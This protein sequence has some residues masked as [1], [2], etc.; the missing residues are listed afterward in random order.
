MDECV[1][2]PDVAGSGQLDLPLEIVGRGCVV[3]LADGR[4]AEAFE[5][6]VAS[7]L[8]FPRGYVSM[9]HEKQLHFLQITASET[10]G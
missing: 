5:Q 8:G 1:R 3:A 9:S 2:A 7:A 10:G 6:S 4:F